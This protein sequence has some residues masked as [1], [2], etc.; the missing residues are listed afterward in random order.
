LPLGSINDGLEMRPF[1]TPIPRSLNGRAQRSRA[2]SG[3]APA[4]TSIRFGE[5]GDADSSQGNGPVKYA[6]YILVEDASG[7]RFQLHQYRR[8]RWFSHQIRFALDTGESVHQL[9]E[10]SFVITKTG[11]TL[12]RIT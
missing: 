6:G 5:S 7:C 8:R 1:A 9:D 4:C 11:E 12:V 3:L 2:L 10:N